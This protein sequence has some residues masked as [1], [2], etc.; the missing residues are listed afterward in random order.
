[1]IRNYKDLALTREQ[2][3]RVMNIL[4][5][6]HEELYAKNPR[7]YALYAE[8]PIDMILQLRAEID[9]FLHIAPAPPETPPVGDN[10]ASGGESVTGNT[11]DGTVAAAGTPESTS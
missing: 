6:T 11:D 9:A 2:L 1:M 4:I 7:N 8:G 5:S 10:G 3:D